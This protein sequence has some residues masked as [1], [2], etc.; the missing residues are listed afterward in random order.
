GLSPGDIANILKT[1][2]QGSLWRKEIIKKRK[3]DDEKMRAQG[4]LDVQLWSRSDGKAFAS[5]LHGIT[6][7]PARAEV[8]IL[9]IGNKRGLQLA[10]QISNNK[11]AWPMTPIP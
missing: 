10:T 7:P 8:K 1:N 3:G 5:Y 11:Q 4:V 2:E 6:G 9:L